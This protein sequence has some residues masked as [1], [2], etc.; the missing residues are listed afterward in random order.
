MSARVMSPLAGLMNGYELHWCAVRWVDAKA[1]VLAVANTI[2]SANINDLVIFI[3]SSLNV[4]FRSGSL[5]RFYL[6]VR[7][8]GYPW[9]VGHAIVDSIS[10]E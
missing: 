4:T 7:F 1:H 2:G 10:A 3:V 5:I 9:N 8:N 6:M